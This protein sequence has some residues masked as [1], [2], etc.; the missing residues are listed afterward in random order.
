M[1][2]EVLEVHDIHARNTCEDVGHQPH[3]QA[4]HN[5]PLQAPYMFHAVQIQNRDEQAAGHSDEP[6]DPE[7]H[8]GMQKE[9]KS[10]DTK[11]GKRTLEAEREPTGNAAER[12]EGCPK[13]SIDEEIGAPGFRHGSGQLCLTE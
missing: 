4:H 5:D 10:A 3:E 12:P 13:A 2:N 9:T 8:R 11:E 6:D 7:I 1:R